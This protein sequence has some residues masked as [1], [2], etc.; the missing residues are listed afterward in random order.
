MMPV[1]QR[2]FTKEIII[3]TSRSSGPGGQHVNKVNTQVQLRFNITESKILT[4]AEKSTLLYRL[5][6]QLT[7]NNELIITAQTER[8]QIQNKKNALDKFYILIEQLLKTEKIRIATKPSK[9]AQT[10]RLENKRRHSDK[11][12]LRRKIH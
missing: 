6:N 10:R 3:L 7:K 8:S 2:D 1:R 12:S 5:R 4:D 9:A 11:K